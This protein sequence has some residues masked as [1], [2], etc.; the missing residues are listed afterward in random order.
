MLEIHS[1]ESNSFCRGDRGC[2]AQLNVSY[3]NYDPPLIVPAT[4]A[5]QFTPSSAIA[6]VR[7][8]AQAFN[9]P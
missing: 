2:A 6:T 3:A 7:C 8:D 4:T 9:A 1:E 5:F